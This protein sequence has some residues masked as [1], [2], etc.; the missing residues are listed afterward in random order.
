MQERILNI[1]TANKIKGYDLIK[2]ELC[3]YPF[4]VW[5]KLKNKKRVS[6]YIRLVVVSNSDNL[7]YW[8]LER[9]FKP[10]NYKHNHREGAN[11]KS[12]SFKRG[13]LDKEYSYFINLWAIELERVIK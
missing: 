6:E 11:I 8:N 7:N 3:D 1:V 2:T 4:F 9:S 10:F 5:Q 13:D 12:Q